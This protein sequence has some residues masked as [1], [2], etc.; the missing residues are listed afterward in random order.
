LYVP[1]I[2]IVEAQL[3]GDVSYLAGVL[4]D[5]MLFAKHMEQVSTRGTQITARTNDWP[6]TIAMR[7]MPYQEPLDGALLKRS[8][9]KAALRDPSR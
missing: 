1:H 8:Q 3:I 7:H 5:Y 9:W 2:I 6:R 4:G